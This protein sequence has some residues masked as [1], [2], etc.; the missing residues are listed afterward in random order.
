[1]IEINQ[2]QIESI[3]EE[4]SKVFKPLFDDF[5][6]EFFN[7]PPRIRFKGVKWGESKRAEFDYFYL[8]EMFDHGYL[9]QYILDFKEREF[10]K[11]NSKTK[12]L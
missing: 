8:L 3:K 2:Q 6:I 11:I 1:M 10:E 4:V 12:A 5:E 9:N 7:E